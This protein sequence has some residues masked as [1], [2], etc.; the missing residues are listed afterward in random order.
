LIKNWTT[1]GLSFWDMKL[2]ASFHPSHHGHPHHHNQPSH[3]HAHD[4]LHGYRINDPSRY[5]AKKMAKPVPFTCLAPQARAVFLVGDFNGWDA[6]S[7]PMQRQPDG[8]WRLQVE[9]NHGHHHYRFLVDG[10]PALDPRANG[11]ARDHLGEKVCVVA[12]S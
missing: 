11:M 1:D 10:Q 7:L 6:T 5:S 9:L 12:V 8:A 3:H 2:N 4:P